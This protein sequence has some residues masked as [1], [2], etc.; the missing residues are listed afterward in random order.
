MNNDL[1]QDWYEKRLA[2]S[3]H[4]DPHF[5]IYISDAWD[6]NWYS[7][8]V[9][10][11]PDF[12]VVDHHLYRCFTTEDHKKSGDELAA[13]IKH[14]TSKHL[15]AMSKNARG[16]LIIGEWSAGLHPDSLR[17]QE[18]GEQDRQRRV[19]AMAQLDCFEEHT[20]GYFFWTY[21]KE[22]GWDAGWSMRDAMQAE[23]LP[24][25]FGQKRPVRPL[26]YDPKT[27]ANSLAKAF[28]KGFEIDG[29]TEHRSKLTANTGQHKDYW[30]AKGGTYEFWRFEEGYSTG[31]DDAMMFVTFPHGG[32]MSVLG[33]RGEWLKQRLACHARDKG[34]S[35]LLWEYGELR[36]YH[37]RDRIEYPTEHGFNEGHD[38]AM[39]AYV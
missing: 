4:I 27:K 13:D 8:L 30:N 31:W 34:A 32:S 25:Y 29:R 16:N 24:P 17:S 23:I 12:V 37:V 39:T 33:M 22:K 20:A 6:L 2:C 9:G 21:K 28:G 26:T 11:R 38:A 3:R 35:G 18:A 36:H 19:F 7:Q 15:S 10:K 14:E 5:P 1:L